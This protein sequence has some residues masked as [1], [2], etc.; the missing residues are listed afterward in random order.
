MNEFTKVT[1][2]MLAQAAAVIAGSYLLGRLYVLA[3]G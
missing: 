2:I 3:F 1:L